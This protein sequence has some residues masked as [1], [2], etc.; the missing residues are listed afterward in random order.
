LG[1]GTTF[2][3]ESHCGASRERTVSIGVARNPA[4][5]GSSIR[6]TFS[7]DNRSGHRVRVSGYVGQFY[8]WILGNAR[9]PH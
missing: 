1:S 9:V 5:A 3:T 8:G 2:V 6:A 7:I 4:T